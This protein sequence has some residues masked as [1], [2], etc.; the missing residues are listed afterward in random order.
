MAK[1]IIKEIIIFLLLLVSIALL[2]GVVFYDYLPNNKALPI[3]PKPYTL[4]ADIQQEIRSVEEQGK[5]IIKTY[6]VDSTDLKI[7]E[8][9]S[10]YKKGKSNPFAPNDSAPSNTSDGNSTGGDN[11]TSG[12]NNTNTSGN[13]T[14]GKGSSVGNF[15]EDPDKK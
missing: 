8:G 13:E 10:Q 1:E 9:T 15:F 7:Y 6:S 11:T 2:L 5:N 4:P 14:T 12:D 3:E